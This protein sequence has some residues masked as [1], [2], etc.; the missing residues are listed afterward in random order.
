MRRRQ[1]AT[2]PFRPPLRSEQLVLRP[3][4]R[5]DAPKVAALAGDWEV[6]R[7]TLDIP[8]P[9]DMTMARDF[10]AWAQDEFS[11]QRRIFLGM[12]ARASG[13]LVGI[14][15]LTRNGT[16]EGEIGY[17]VGRPYQG[18]GYAREA[19]AVA[20][21]LGFEVMALRRVVAACMPDNEP[22]WRVME[23]C[24][25][26]YVEAIQR[27]S[28]ARRETFDLSLYAIDRPAEEANT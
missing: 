14:I 16:D 20:I 8:H 28:I 4:E 18:K 7:W 26:T 25:M 10:V 15:S 11:S 2:L 13:D 23:H 5:T 27:W 9:Y 19:A 17:W 6:A 24:G 21:K 3:L 1:T 22:S 12:V